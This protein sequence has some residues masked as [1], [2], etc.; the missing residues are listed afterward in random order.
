MNRTVDLVVVLRSANFMGDRTFDA[1][2]GVVLTEDGSG[3]DHCST[4]SVEL[5]VSSVVGAVSFDAGYPTME[6][7]RVEEDG[8]N[9]TDVPLSRGDR[10]TC[11]SHGQLQDGLEVVVTADDGSFASVGTAVILMT[12]P[13]LLADVTGRV[14]ALEAAIAAMNAPSNNTP[15]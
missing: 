10:V 12:M 1:F 2:T 11:V 14:E 9:K 4:T 7:Y 6:I 13:H 15:E 5:P 3:V 8:L